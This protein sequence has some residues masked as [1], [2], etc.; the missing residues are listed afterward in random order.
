M[1]LILRNMVTFTIS[2]VDPVLRDGNKEVFAEVEDEELTEKV[3]G[4]LL[5]NLSCAYFA[6][7]LKSFASIEGMNAYNL[8]LMIK[9]YEEE[10][11]KD[12]TK[13]RTKA[14]QIVMSYLKKD[15][16]RIE[17]IT[18]KVRENIE[19]DLERLDRNLFITLFGIVINKLEE[20]YV[21]FRQSELY[22]C[23]RWDLENRKVI[24][25]RLNYA[26]LM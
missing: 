14:S 11:D 2:F 1:I 13:A 10:V 3:E 4:V 22:K 24:L 20:Y 16:L 23:L 21:I 6:E 15:S 25:Q 8:Y 5:G 26:G 17:E 12:L 9:E 18:D 19:R 7:F